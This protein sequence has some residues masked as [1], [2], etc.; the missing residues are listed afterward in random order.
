MCVCVCKCM[1][2]FKIYLHS[3]SSA[4]VLV[5]LAISPRSPAPSSSRCDTV[6]SLPAKALLLG[7]LP[8]RRHLPRHSIVDRCRDRETVRI[9]LIRK[10][11][12]KKS[13][14]R[15]QT[16]CS[17]HSPISLPPVMTSH[18]QDIASAISVKGLTATRKADS[19]RSFTKYTF[20]ILHKLIH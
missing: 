9:I 8:K 2:I 20:L 19:F 17:K 18:I 6:K 13:R 3:R 1:C 11:G 7:Y 4:G 10:K 15:Y 16:R 14:Y 12:L 5:A